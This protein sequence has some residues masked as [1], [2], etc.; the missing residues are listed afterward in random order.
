[1]IGP[2]A[3]CFGG[4]TVVKGDSDPLSIGAVRPGTL[5]HRTDS[6]QG[7]VKVYSMSDEFND[8]AYYANSSYA[9]YSIDGSLFKRVENNIARADEI[10]P[11]QVALPAGSYTIVVRSAR[12]GKVRVHFVIKADQRTIV[13]L[14]LAEREASLSHS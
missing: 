12:A 2:L 3:F 13:D 5:G 10:I 1:L 9:I 8:G 4:S 14:D 7:Y 6:A 11:W